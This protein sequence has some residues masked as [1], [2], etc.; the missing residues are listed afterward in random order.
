MEYRIG[1][2]FDLH[3]L[4]PGRRLVLAGVAVPF[5]QGLLG[6][7]DADALSHAVADALL[8]ALALG[9]LGQHFPDTDPA[10][11]DAD[12]LKLLARVAALIE[13]QGYAVVNLDATIIAERPKLS[14][15]FPAMAENLARVL[16]IPAA[17]V[18]V[19][20]KT[21]EGTDAVG[22]GEAIAAQAIALLQKK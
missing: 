2:G 11:K 8:G 1:Q 20:A 18:S 19:K 6:H 14:P 13:E 10:W 4:S 5:D 12:S 21:A 15:H 3:R 17:R 22:R 7:S 9:D 16:K